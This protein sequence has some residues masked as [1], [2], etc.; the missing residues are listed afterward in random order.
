ML[1]LILTSTLAVGSIMTPILQV[2][3]LSS[4]RWSCWVTCLGMA[5]GY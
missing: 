2:R 5:K 4:P 3:K 1:L